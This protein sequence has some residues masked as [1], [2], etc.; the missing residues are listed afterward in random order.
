MSVKLQQTLRELYGLA[1]NI[2]HARAMLAKD[3]GTRM[4]F[5][6]ELKRAKFTLDNIIT[7]WEKPI[8][9]QRV[10]SSEETKS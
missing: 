10:R 5:L 7:D 8:P 1:G 3:H 9:G 2:H 6:E 4:E